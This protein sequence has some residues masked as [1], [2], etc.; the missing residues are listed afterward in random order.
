MPKKGDHPCLRRLLKIVD[1]RLPFANRVKQLRR[2]QQWLIDLEH[3]LD[4][5]RPGQSQPPTRQ[6]VSQ[7]VDHYLVALLAQVANETN[8]QD[9]AVAAHLERT[10]RNHW[11]GLFTCYAVEGLPCTN[12]ELE[13]YLRQIKMGQR[14][15]SGRKNV[16]N[17]IIRYGRYATC[18]DPQESLTELLARLQQVTQEDFLQERQALEIVILCEQKRHRFCHHRSDYLTELEQRWATA[19]EQDVS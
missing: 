3:L 5:T 1:Q 11:W 10:V 15:I 12:N 2:Q 8:A 16:H 13:R 17:F 14:R 19:V 9:Q 7:A 6:T 18:L 4:P